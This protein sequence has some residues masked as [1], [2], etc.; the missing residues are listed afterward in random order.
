M[1]A[2][3]ITLAIMLYK[4][5]EYNFYGNVNTSCSQCTNL[6]LGDGQWARTEPFAAATTLTVV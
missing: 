1:V 3:T 4:Y 5:N 2:V 6:L